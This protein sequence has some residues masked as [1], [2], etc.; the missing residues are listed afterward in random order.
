MTTPRFLM[1]GEY[2]FGQLAL[3]HGERS[4]RA[5]HHAARQTQDHAI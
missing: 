1:P 5:E 4:K 3:V 2:L